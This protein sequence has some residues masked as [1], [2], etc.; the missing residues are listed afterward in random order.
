V[1]HEPPLTELQ[2]KVEPPRVPCEYLAV[3]VPPDTEE[4]NQFPR[5]LCALKASAPLTTATT[6]IEVSM[7]FIFFIIIGAF[8][9]QKA[10]L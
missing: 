2:N 6:A 5:R 9:N 10:K 3:Q 4:Q 1:V 7:I 8:Y